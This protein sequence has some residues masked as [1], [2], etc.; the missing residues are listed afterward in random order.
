MEIKVF[1]ISEDAYEEKLEKKDIQN[2]KKV[3]Q[4]IFSSE[5]ADHLRIDCSAREDSILNKY[6]NSKTI[7]NMYEFAESLR[8]AELKKDGTRNKQITKGNLF[9]KKEDEQLILL[10]LENIE[11]VDKEKNYEMKT[12]FSTEANY[13]KGCIFD[14]NLN[15]VV[16]IDRN[17]T[18]AKYW[19]ED[20]LK[21]SLNRDSYQNSID[22][23]DLLKENKL[24]SENISSKGNLQEIKEATENYIFK[25][26]SFDK[27]QLKELLVEKSLI[28]DTELNLVYSESSKNIDTGFEISKKAIKKRYHKEIFVSEDTKI[29]TDNYEKLIRRQGIEYEDGKIIL[30]V[31]EKFVNNLPKELTDGN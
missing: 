19:R 24:F 17:K 5:N 10:K 7:F 29:W 4:K 12:S 15:K 23:I 8:G 25:N 22:L 21:L 26:E 27:T 28:R 18:I 6:M 1:D 30:S 11:V 16:V 31:S 2:I 14:G 20:F 3:F 9:I 13:Y